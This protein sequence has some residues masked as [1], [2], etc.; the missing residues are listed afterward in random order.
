[1]SRS[2]L[3]RAVAVVAA[4]LLGVCVAWAI[5]PRERSG[6]LES[7]PPRP[8]VSFSVVEKHDGPRHE[9]SGGRVRVRSASVAAANEAVRASRAPTRL[10]LPTLG[11]TL[12]VRATGVDEQ[13][14]MALP[15][16]A[17]A[18][19]WYRFGSGP[20]DRRGATVVAG[21]VDTAAEGTGPL[22]GLAAVR[23]GDPV[24]LWVGDRRV[25]YRV[26]EI[27]RVAKSVLDLPALFTRAGPPRLH[28]VTCGGDYLPERGGY[29]DNVVLTARPVA[30]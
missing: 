12:P 25:R 13:G 29:Q 21:H 5:A 8:P 16:T 15:E 27:A 20:L 23:R 18:V 22:A 11:L 24:S 9:T 3:Q 17:Y 28:L 1:M 4:A 19:G 2:P 14:L 10:V 30:G 6:A 7:V 26:V